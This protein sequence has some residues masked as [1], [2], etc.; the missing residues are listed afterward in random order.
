MNISTVDADARPSL[1]RTQQTRPFMKD[2]EMHLSLVEDSEIF[3]ATTS[4]PT[5]YFVSFA[6]S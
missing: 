5:S 3:P 2:G 1:P 4:T 6:E